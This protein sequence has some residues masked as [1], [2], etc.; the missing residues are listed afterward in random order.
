MEG[1]ISNTASLLGLMGRG[2]LGWDG[3]LA[4]VRYGDAQSR[5][6]RSAGDVA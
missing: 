6:P 2:G 1:R 3:L 4:D 5:L